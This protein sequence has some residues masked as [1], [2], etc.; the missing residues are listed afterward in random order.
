MALVSV[1]YSAGVAGLIAARRDQT[2]NP[3]LAYGLCGGFAF[4]SIGFVAWAILFLE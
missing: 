3:G 4:L 2:A 1:A